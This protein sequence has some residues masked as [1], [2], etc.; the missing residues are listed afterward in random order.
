MMT[1]WV[2]LEG[3]VVPVEVEGV[4]EAEEG[5]LGEAVEIISGILVEEG[6]DLLMQEKIS[7]TSVVIIQMVMVS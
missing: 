6:E 3:V 7:K 2:G 5:T 1:T 4:V